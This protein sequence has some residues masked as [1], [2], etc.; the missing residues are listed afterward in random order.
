M[1]DAR[2]SVPSV[3]ALLRSEPGRRAAASL[4]R[5]LLKRC[6]AVTLDE[7]R[8]AAAGGAEVPTADDILARAC[9]R[10]SRIASGLTPV[11]NATGVILH[12]NLG[13]AP[14]PVDAA[15]AA[16]RAASAYADL[17]VDRATGKRGRRGGRAEELLIALTGAED[18]LVVNNCAA[19]LLLALAALAKRKEVLV[20]RGELIEIGGE[21]RIPDIMGASGAKLVEVGTTNRTR[22]GDYR[23]AVSDR[24]G[25]ILK[26][27]PSNYRVVGFTAEASAKDLAALADK[28]GVPFLYDVG[29]GLLAH[30]HGM[31]PDEPSVADAL[32]DGAGLVLCSGDKLLGGPQAGIVVGRAELVAKLRRHPVARAVRIDAMQVAALESVLSMYA[33]GR[34]DDIPVH[35]MLRETAESVHHRAQALCEKLG[36][37]L[38]Y[39][40]VHKCHSVVGGGSTPGAS[41]P[42]YGI[43]VTVPD[44][45]GFAARLRVGNPSVFCRVEDGAVLLDLRTVA[46]TEE[47]HLARALLYALE[48]DDLYED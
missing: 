25:A 10:A 48:G 44:P 13:R 32:A 29:S 45:A 46:P 11:I 38:E 42:S 12:T 14:L 24:T 33:T 9:Q 15:R 41:L 23:A 19:A 34:D 5:L 2:R 28:R 21:F 22:I 3:D 4:G 20:S 17:E 47:P 26:V 30:G 36:G 6:L 31:P 43:R 8:A 27:H 18:V 40:H 37:D 35:R 7:V 39:A 1:V 16:A